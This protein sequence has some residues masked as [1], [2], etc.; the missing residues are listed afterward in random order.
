V[1]PWHKKCPHIFLA[2]FLLCLGEAEGRKE[3]GG[4]S[5][6]VLLALWAALWALMG[7]NSVT[8][9]HL[10]ELEPVSRL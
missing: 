8:T 5:L 4:H 2:A 10:G 6:P 1:L 3:P 9:D 7:L